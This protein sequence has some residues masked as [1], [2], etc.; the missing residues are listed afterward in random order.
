[1]REK[2][3]RHWRGTAG[4]VEDSKGGHCEGTNLHSELLVH[5]SSQRRDEEEGAESR[6]PDAMV[7]HRWRSRPASTSQ[8][9]TFRR[10]FA[11]ISIFF[12]FPL[13]TGI[14]NFAIFRYILFQNSKF[15]K[16]RPKSTEIYRNLPKFRNEISFPLNTGISSENE[17]VNPALHALIVGH[18]ACE[19]EGK[20]Q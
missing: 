9:L 5:P 18:V 11:E 17:M 7:H 8:V 10:N 4:G 15:N 14:R 12:S 1:M 16:F 6:I 3:T 20:I 2:R 19:E 13:V